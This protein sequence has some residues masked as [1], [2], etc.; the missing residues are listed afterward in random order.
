MDES[1]TQLKAML[2]K[3][4]AL[5]MEEKEL[6]QEMLGVECALLQ[7]ALECQK[8]ICAIKE[9]DVKKAMPSHTANTTLSPTTTA[10]PSDHTISCDDHVTLSELCISPDSVAELLGVP[11]EP[12][13]IS[14][15]R[16]ELSTLAADKQRLEA[17]QR[18][19]HRK[20]KAT[21]SAMSEL[22]QVC[23]TYIWWAGQ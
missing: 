5:L 6:Q 9:H 19:L 3:E 18:R 2:L 11:F 14:S 12:L 21:K 8:R 1:F 7:N 15:S 20:L 13:D 10:T 16:E 17:H 23:V 4:K 22:Q